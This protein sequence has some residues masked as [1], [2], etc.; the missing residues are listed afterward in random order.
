MFISPE[1][2][3]VEL[4]KTGCTHIGKLLAQVLDGQQVGKH[5]R[6]TDKFLTVGSRFFLGSVRN[7]WDWYVSL[8]AYGCDHKGGLYATVTAPGWRGLLR[9]HG[10]KKGSLSA[11]LAAAKAIKAG[12]HPDLWARCYSERDDAENF[13]QWLRLLN[14]RAYWHEIGEGYAHSAVCRTAGVLTYRYLGLFCRDII[15]LTSRHSMRDYEDLLSFERRN[16]YIDHFIRNESLE[17]DLIRGLAACGV[18]VSEEQQSKILSSGK[19]NTSSRSNNTAYYY[20]EATIALVQDRERLI[21]EK[22]S[23]APPTVQ[24]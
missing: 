9:G 18:A 6:P 5:N 20:D 10:W 2:I 23:Y 19:T 12:K 16:C 4:Q 21:I 17:S 13:R 22:F 7:P 3:F 15:P 1:I 24:R 14:D 11:T 8:W